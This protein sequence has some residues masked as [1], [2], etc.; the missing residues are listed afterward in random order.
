MEKIEFSYLLEFISITGI[1]IKETSHFLT[2]ASKNNL[3]FTDIPY[4]MAG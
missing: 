2:N 3:S 4:K 1:F